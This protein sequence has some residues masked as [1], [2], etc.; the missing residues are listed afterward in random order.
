MPDIG[1]TGR[2]ACSSAPEN[3]AVPA[4]RRPLHNRLALAI[5]FHKP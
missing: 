2:F 5:Q 4:Y 1:F 3:R